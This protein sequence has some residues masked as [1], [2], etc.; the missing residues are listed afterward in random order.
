MFLAHWFEEDA[1]VTTYTGDHDVF[2]DGS[3]TLLAMPGHTPGH[4]AMMVRLPK[5]GPVLLT[6]DLYHFRSEIG[7]QIVSN[8]NTSRAETLA[9]YAR[10]E[11]IVARIAP[12]VTVQ[13]D[14]LDIDKLPAFPQSAK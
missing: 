8:R 9:S 13:H 4:S 7:T 2:G 1:A 14:P 10:L 11:Q 5:T 12:L 6:G 3:V